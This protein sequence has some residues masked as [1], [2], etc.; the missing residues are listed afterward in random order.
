[1]KKKGILFLVIGLILVFSMLFT[2]CS[3][4]KTNEERQAS[5]VIA[6]VSV[7]LVKEFGEDVKVLG[8]DWNYV[9]SL[10]ITRREI[11]YTVNYAV[12]Y[13]S[14][15]YSQYELSYDYDLEDMIESSLKS[16]KAQKYNTIR[17]MGELLKS[18]KRQGAFY[19]LTPEYQ[20]IYGKAL[21][22]EGVLTVAERYAV[23]KEVN[24]QFETRLEGYL[25]DT[26]ES[27][28]DAEKSEADDEI[29]AL[30]AKGYF[31]SE[32]SVASKGDDGKFKD[33]LYKTVV[34]DDNDSDTEDL[35]FEK[36]YA[37]VKLVLS[38]SEDKYVYVPIEATALT[39]AEDE[40]ADATAKYVT[41][42]TAVVSFGGR[43]EAE[44][45]EDD[46]TGYDV[47]TFK[48]KAEK[49]TLYAAKTAPTKAEDEEEEE[50]IDDVR[51]ATVAQWTALTAEADDDLS[52]A[53]NELKT[54]I[55]NASPEKY[56]NNDQ[57]DAYRRLRDYFT[58]SKIGYTTEK[59][60][61]NGLGYYY[62]SEFA[63]HVLEAE[64]YELGAKLT[65]VAATDVTK[66]YEYRVATDKA[67]YDHLTEEEQV[68]KFFSTLK[69]SDSILNGLENVYYVPVDA[70]C[71]VEFEIKS[72]DKAYAPLFDAAGELTADGAKYARKDAET[73]KFYMPYAYKNDDGT[74]TINMF[75]A[76]HILLS[77]D[78][79]A[80]LSDAYK[81]QS[82]AHTDESKIALVK[83]YVA[84]IA[85]M[86]QKL[87]FLENYDAEK[88][89]DLVLSD[90]YEVDET[91][92]E[93]VLTDYA[94]AEQIIMDKLNEV[95]AENDEEKLL[96]A[97]VTLMEQYND[98]SGKLTHSGY[99]VSV[100][101][102]ENGWYADFTATAINMYFTKLVAGEKP[103]GYVT[104][105]DKYSADNNY[106]YSDYGVHYMFLTFAPLY[107]VSIDA[108][109]G[110]GENTILD[111]DKDTRSA[112]INESLLD[113][114]KSAAYSD[115]Q[116]KATDDDV[117]A[118]TTVNEK[119]Y[120]RMLKD[121]KG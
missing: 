106:A 82:E 83:L 1:M 28:R 14:Q 13:Y 21:T 19:C 29:S 46:D 34:I 84:R 117:D 104:V 65:E 2:A 47:E 81:T 114:A 50:M 93:I 35:D 120:K 108:N 88:A 5:R 18:E 76:T 57:K 63:S 32:I 111:L 37:K 33:G 61:Y 110:I 97:F 41:A 62:L 24:E 10:D 68:S 9:V 55:F 36:V 8:N 11:I 43:V 40:D 44:V 45:T 4:V 87:S 70:L 103:V 105:S 77:L 6:T 20:A 22:P 38:G 48:S 3:L 66:E 58:S 99:L 30:Y 115:W 17:A 78:D 27:E 96:D 26:K 100:G 54:D 51:Y 102:M 113:S 12:S 92:G 80:G 60:A 118:H 42:K 107:N 64:E 39:L 56:D 109:G 69:G 25:E 31:V 119:Y 86:A 72:T 95:Y 91:T 15:L 90:L 79:V 59:D 89:A 112:Q 16:L 75:Y 67:N 52:K 7:D 94:D 98:D 101:D 121:I 49:Y 116:A 73:G 23:V 74:Y 71:N 85:T 53:M